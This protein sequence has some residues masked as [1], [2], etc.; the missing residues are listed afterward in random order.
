M[1]PHQNALMNG[2]SPEPLLNAIAA[3]ELTFSTSAL[4]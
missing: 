1:Q 2:G 3:E 4:L